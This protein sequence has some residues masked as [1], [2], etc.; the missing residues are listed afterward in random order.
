MHPPVDKSAKRIGPEGMNPRSGNI[1]ANDIREAFLEEIRYFVKFF[2][3]LTFSY[4]LFPFIKSN[5]S[6]SLSVNVL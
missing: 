5:H 6:P 1:F 4:L 2:P 3:S